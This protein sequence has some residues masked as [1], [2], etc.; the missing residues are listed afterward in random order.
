MDVT[1]RQVVL[2][3]QVSIALDAERKIAKRHAVHRLAL[4]T[5]VLVA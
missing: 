4:F 1:Q 5:A 3:Q 2:R